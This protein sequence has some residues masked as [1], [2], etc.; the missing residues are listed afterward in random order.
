MLRS[1]LFLILFSLPLFAD[2]RVYP[3]RLTLSDTKRVGDVSLRHTGTQPARYKISTVFYRMKEDGSMELSKSPQKEDRSAIDL[4]RFSPRQVTLP[5]NLEQVIRVMYSGPKD[6]AQGE[7][8]AHL[9][10]EPM[11]EPELEPK[12][13]GE[14]VQMRLQA[15]VAIA[16][17]VIFKQGKVEFTAKLSN[18]KLVKLPDGQP[19]YS[20]DLTGEGNGF[21]YGD[22]LAFFTPAG[23]TKQ[24]LGIVRS[25]ASYL[26]KRKISY[27]FTVPENTKIANGKLTLEY[28]DTEEDGGKVLA[29]TETQVP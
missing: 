17:P 27:P 13:K 1:S 5:P 28:R 18:L 9:L 15:K 11:D 25:V 10:F 14:Q 2:L 23:K 22:V 21:P 16:V 26:K 4:I 3:T 24:S 19:G 29:S 6:L 20:V 12:A 8:R 7:Y